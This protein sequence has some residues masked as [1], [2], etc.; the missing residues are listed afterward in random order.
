MNAGDS[1][2]HQQLRKAFLRSGR[3]ERDAI[4]D[5]LVSRGAQQQPR[6]AAIIERR[7]QFLPR[8]LKLCSGA[9]VPKFV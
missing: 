6:I 1:G 4:K 9:H 7:A 3:A 2:T 8:R 5:D